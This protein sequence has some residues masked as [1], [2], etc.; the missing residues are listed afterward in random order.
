MTVACV[1]GASGF[2]G[3]A[4]V[5]RLR[6][7]GWRVLPACR[8]RVTPAGAGIGNWPELSESR[9]ARA[10]EGVDA[11]YHLAGLTEAARGVSTAQFDAVNKQ[12]TLRMYGAA[13]AAGVSTFIWLSTIKV[14]G[15]V[16]SEPLR[17]DAPHAP[18]GDYSLSKAHTERELLALE[19]AATKLVIVRPPLVYGPGVKGNF[20]ALMRLCGTGL[21]LPF[22]GARARRSLLGLANLVDF[23]ARLPSANLR[24][25]DVLHVCDAR[26]WRVCD[27]VA[28]LQKLHG[29]APRQFPL[30]R[31]L[32]RTLA[33]PLGLS[34]AVSRLFDPLRV[35]AQGSQRRLGWQPPHTA[36]DLLKET[37]AWT[38]RAH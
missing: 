25:A 19:S 5:R 20:A 12:L 38:R 3:R 29:H 33:A 4:L 37:V 30:A 31:S 16:A 10:L 11:V 22:A 26:D 24:G 23:L 2:I 21:P 15:D 14:L 27:L 7:G 36:Q 6:E 13:R 1:T 17:P 32:A 8:N 28:R 34:G 9:L 35:D 18:I